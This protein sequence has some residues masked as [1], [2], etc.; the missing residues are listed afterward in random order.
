MSGSQRAA[1]G[2]AAS[3]ALGNWLERQILGPNPWLTES[4]TLE[5]G[6]SNLYLNRPAG[7]ADAY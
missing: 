4:E 7:D 6:P 3:A 5:V 2:L 1:L